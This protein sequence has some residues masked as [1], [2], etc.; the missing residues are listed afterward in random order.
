MRFFLGLAAALLAQA[1]FSADWLEVAGF[2]DKGI[3]VYVDEA[4]LTAEH[5]PV[6]QG[7]VRFSYDKPR[8]LSGE[9]L[10]GHSSLRM[11]DCRERRYWVVENWGYRPDDTRVRLHSSAQEWQLAPPDS[12]DQVALDALCLSARSLPG[13]LWDKAQGMFLMLRMGLGL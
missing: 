7:W 13:V 10:L 3:K 4:S 6:V 8:T 12:E 9:P 1:C 2:P 5:E 11:V